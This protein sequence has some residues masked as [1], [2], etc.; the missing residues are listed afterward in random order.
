MKNAACIN[1]TDGPIAK[2]QFGPVK[3]IY[4]DEAAIFF[5]LPFGMPPVGEMRWKPPQPFH[6]SW[7]PTTY[8]ATFPRPGCYQVSLNYYGQSLDNRIL[9]TAR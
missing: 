1:A 7:A 5:G 3:G 8:D 4:A 2:T 6:T 9:I